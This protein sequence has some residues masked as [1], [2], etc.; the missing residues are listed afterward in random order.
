[1]AETRRPRADE[2]PDSYPTPT[3]AWKAIEAQAQR[4]LADNAKAVEFGPP[5][6]ALIERTYPEDNVLRTR[7]WAARVAQA[8]LAQTSGPHEVLEALRDSLRDAY[9][10]RGFGSDV[11]MPPAPTSASQRAV[12]GSSE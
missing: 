4:L 10:A 12:R 1:M 8:Y 7:T 9:F 11:D 6:Q 3:D 5:S 2:D